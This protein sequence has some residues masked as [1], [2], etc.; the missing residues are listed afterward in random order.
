MQEAKGNVWGMDGDAIAILTNGQWDGTG[1]AVMGGGIAREARDRLK[2]CDLALG[3]LLRNYGNHVFL[4]GPYQGKELVSF[5]TKDH[6]KNPSS[7]DLIA[8]SCD[9]L[10]TLTDRHGWE[11]VLVPRPGCGLGGLDWA[12]VKP[13]CEEFFDDDRF[14]V[15]T[16]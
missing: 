4:L 3:A 12:D 10:V 8:E 16:F 7:L 2:G 6:W 1:H 15:V 14:V 13:V 9:E 11:Q 5:P